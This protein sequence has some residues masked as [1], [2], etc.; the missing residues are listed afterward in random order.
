MIAGT[1]LV[2]YQRVEAHARLVHANL[3]HSDQ[4]GVTRASLRAFF[5]CIV[6]TP[7]L[8]LSLSLFLPL[9]S[10]RRFAKVNV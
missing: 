6:H 1:L 8:S 5:P 7:S 9:A 4:T 10:L 2:A 3:Q